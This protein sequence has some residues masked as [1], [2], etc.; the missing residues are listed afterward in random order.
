[1]GDEFDD[2]PGTVSSAEMQTYYTA[3]FN[4]GQGR[5]YGTSGIHQ[6][7]DAAIESMATFKG[8]KD[9]KVVSFDLPVILPQ[10]T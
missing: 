9:I 7:R 5:W 4:Y 10:E 8:A 3:V 2:V 6:T 1:M